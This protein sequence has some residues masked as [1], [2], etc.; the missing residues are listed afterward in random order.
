VGVSVGL[1][2]A[3]G[4]AV[5]GPAGAVLSG[6]GAHLAFE[7]GKG[8]NLQSDLNKETVRRVIV[9]ETAWEA[10]S[11]FGFWLGL[12]GLVLLLA[13]RRWLLAPLVAVVCFIPKMVIK[14]RKKP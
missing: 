9:R 2:A 3:A 6:A 14:M 1:A 5:A 11:R 13:E 10:A 4:G 8:T 12:I 7:A